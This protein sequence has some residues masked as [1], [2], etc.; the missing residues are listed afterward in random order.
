MQ[1][2]QSQEPGF[3]G[4]SLGPDED[5]PLHLQSI[6]KVDKGVNHPVGRGLISFQVESDNLRLINAVMHKVYLAEI[7]QCAAP[8]TQNLDL[9]G[10]EGCT[11]CDPRALYL[12]KHQV[13]ANPDL[14]KAV[15]YKPKTAFDGAHFEYRL[16]TTGAMPSLPKE[17]MQ[18]DAYHRTFRLLSKLNRSNAAAARLA[19]IKLQE[20]YSRN[21]VAFLTPYDFQNDIY[22]LPIHA[23]VRLDSSS[24]TIRV[25]E[26]PASQYHT[27]Y[28]LLSFNNCLQQLCNTNPRML[29]F[30]LSNLLMISSLKAD[31][32]NMY[33]SIAF[34]YLSSLYF[35][36]YC[37]RSKQNRPT[38]VESNSDKSGLHPIR[39]RFLRFGSSQSPAVSQFCLVQCVKVYYNDH[40]PLSPIDLF[41]YSVAKK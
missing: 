34:D 1:S 13:Y 4:T 7:V 16:L 12:R 25:C 10:K 11:A 31:I 3:E 15:T 27:K 17:K 22:Y 14:F 41:Y 35:V 19:S 38:Y 28:G 37:F 8:L 39:C 21:G 36:T 24:T 18:L 9:S 5:C 20:L 29:L 33:G 40:Q 2:I 6:T 32:Q 26:S 23:V 30:P